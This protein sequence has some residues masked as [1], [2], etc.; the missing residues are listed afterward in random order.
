MA[1][2]DGSQPDLTFNPEKN[3]TYEIGSKNSFFDN[4]LQVN[5]ALYSIKT[6]GIQ[7]SGPSSV[8]TNPGLVTKNF[9]SVKTKGFEIELA[10]KVA[11]GVRV[12]L[13]VGYADPEFGADAFDFGA[14]AGCASFSTVTNTF[15]PI[16]PA[17]A[18]RVVRLA[19]SSE[20]N[21]STIA[22]NALSLKG[23]SLPRETNLMLNGGIDLEGP[24]GESGWKW[25]GNFTARW[26]DKQYAFNNNI[27]WYGPRTIINMRAGVENETYSASLYVNNLTNDHT[28]EIVSVNARL[29]DF[30]GD[31]N[32]Y[33]PIGRQYGITVGAKF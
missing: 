18:G 30:G 24:I 7:I 12:N 6:K 11:D 27:S 32:G 28:P 21:N 14:A 25:T 19:P 1:A 33:L 17:C 26:E 3:T 8:A 4:K 22:R 31:L 16:I 29:S 15:T 2:P 20:F 9:G 23:L 10:A 5:F 13:G